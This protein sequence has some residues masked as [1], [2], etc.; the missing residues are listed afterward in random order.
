MLHQV[1]VL[2]Y[3]LFV[4][5]RDH[6]YREGLHPLLA[7]GG[8]DRVVLLLFLGRAGLPLGQELLEAGLDPALLGLRR[9]RRGRFLLPFLRRLLEFFVLDGLFDFVRERFF[10]HLIPPT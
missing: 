3:E 9:R 8:Q 6:L 10:R 7:P 2:A 4:R 5:G 1:A